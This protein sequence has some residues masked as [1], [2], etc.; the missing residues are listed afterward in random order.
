LQLLHQEIAIP[1][2]HAGMEYLAAGFGCRNGLVE[3]FA[4]AVDHVSLAVFGFT[5]L[6]ESVYAVDVVNIE[7][8]KIENGLCSPSD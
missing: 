6:N 8:A 2:S 3:P 5:G 4:A 1:A 7:G